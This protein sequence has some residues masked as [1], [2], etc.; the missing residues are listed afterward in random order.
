MHGVLS[1]GLLPWLEK[2]HDD[3][4]ATTVVIVARSKEYVRASPDARGTLPQVRFTLG[5]KNR[6]RLCQFVL[7]HPPFL[8]LPLS[9]WPHLLCAW[10]CAQARRTRQRAPDALRGY[11]T[12]MAFRWRKSVQT[13]ALM[14]WSRKEPSPLDEMSHSQRLLVELFHF[15]ATTPMAKIHADWRPLYW[16]WWRRLTLAP[17]REP[18]AFPPRHA[19]LGVWH[20]ALNGHRS[21][22]QALCVHNAA[23]RRLAHLP[24]DRHYLAPDHAVGPWDADVRQ[25]AAALPVALP[26]ERALESSRR[27][28]R[29]TLKRREWAW[30]ASKLSEHLAGGAFARVEDLEHPAQWRWYTAAH[31]SP[32]DWH[33]TLRAFPA[34]VVRV[35]GAITPDRHTPFTTVLGFASESDEARVQLATHLHRAPRVAWYMEAARVMQQFPDQR[36]AVRLDFARY[37]FRCPTLPAPLLPWLTRQRTLPQLIAPQATVA[38]SNAPPKFRRLWAPG[39]AA[40]RERV[41]R[42]GTRTS[43][44]AETPPVAWTTA[45]ELVRHRVPLHRLGRVEVWVQEAPVT[46]ARDDP[47][48]ASPDVFTWWHRRGG[49]SRDIQY[50]DDAK[51]LCRWEKTFRDVHTPEHGTCTLPEEDGTMPHDEWTVLRATEDSPVCSS[52]FLHVWR[53]AWHHDP[54][55]VYDGDLEKT[56]AEA[57][58]AYGTGSMF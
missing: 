48:S 46:Q 7:R 41:Q 16:W 31:G 37:A 21:A 4:G 9:Q 13:D 8:R 6:D 51:E 14:A 2:N 24:S 20:S 50:D 18:W 49:H 26:A 25:L 23:F 42:I 45:V 40:L 19:I 53:E 57:Q 56:V 1:D 47:R 54:D 29:T 32:Q 30:V 39:S 22:L 55:T 27:A 28:V 10:V 58:Q 5:R 34:S 36:N 12:S 3:A 52:W 17:R 33:H 38:L 35:L 43:A 11:R 15:H 44:K